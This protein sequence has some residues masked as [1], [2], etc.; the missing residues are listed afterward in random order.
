MSIR[1][2]AFSTLLCLAAL[3]S[4]DAQ[5]TRVF[6]YDLR[7][8]PLTMPAAYAI[9][10]GD[11]YEQ[12]SLAAWGA[13]GIVSDGEVAGLLYVQPFVDSTTVGSP[14]RLTSPDARPSGFV[15]VVAVRDRFV[16]IWTDVRDP[17]RP[18]VYGRTV[19]A[20]GSSLGAERPLTDRIPTG[21]IERYGD[22]ANGRVVR[23]RADSGATQAHLFV[24]FDAAGDPVGAPRLVTAV[25][26]RQLHGDITPWRTIIAFTDGDALS[27]DEERSRLDDGEIPSG[28]FHG[29]Y[30]LHG[31]GSI[32]VIEG[33]ALRTYASATETVAEESIVL[34]GFDSVAGGVAALERE[35]GGWAVTFARLVDR[36]LERSSS[37]LPFVLTL[38]RHRYDAAGMLLA[39]DTLD[40][41]LIWEGHQS[42]KI[43]DDYRL[44]SA[45]IDRGCANGSL[46]V[47]D[48]ARKEWHVTFGYSDTPYRTICREVATVAVDGACRI[49]PRANRCLAPPLLRL[50]VERTRSDSV[51]AVVV[52]DGSFERSLEIDNGIDSGFDT[53][54]LSHRRREPALGVAGDTIL[55][56]FT[57]DDVPALSHATYTGDFSPALTHRFDATGMMPH[58]GYQEIFG[59]LVDSSGA[60]RTYRG[61]G[62]AAA[63]SWP[64]VVVDN[65]RQH[66]NYLNSAHMS[67]VTVDVDKQF[68]AFPTPSGWRMIA[69]DSL[70]PV[71]WCASCQGWD[72][73]PVPRIARDPNTGLLMLQI[74]PLREGYPEERFVQRATAFIDRYGDVVSIIAEQA[75][76]GSWSEV[77]PADDRG[78]LG[79][80]SDSLHHVSSASTRLVT[81]LS[82]R[83]SNAVAHRLLGDRFLRVA[84]V[85]SNAVALDLFD[86]EGVWMASDTLVGIDTATMIVHEHPSDTT[87]TL[88]WSD[89]LGI[90]AARYSARLAP[91]VR[92][93]LLVAGSTIA[94]LAVASVGD[95]LRFVWE[96]LRYGY[97]DLYTTTIGSLPSAMSQPADTSGIPDQPNDSSGMIS[98]PLLTDRGEIVALTVVPNPARNTITVSLRLQ[99][100]WPVTITIV[101]ET[102]RSVLLRDGEPGVAGENRFALDIGELMPGAYTVVLKAGRG[103][104]EG[105]F[106]IAR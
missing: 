19:H 70:R 84:P 2:A 87:L 85:G 73:G 67:R 28:R 17:G 90:H 106:V 10:G 12:R 74:A 39:S 53:V 54:L 68:H 79:I 97:P 88:L 103:Q 18:M 56:T 55:L 20:D 65:W 57:E 5:G 40:R 63:G 26:E 101:D 30:F 80:R 16:V 9:E 34:H 23:W 29:A 78:Y 92:D 102:G 8:V 69:N 7:H 50:R 35:G 72:T 64:G 43:S 31:D 46:L 81:T 96:D 61:F 4:A 13:Y 98:I 22:P 77:I 47:Y 11:A 60:Y 15:D 21:S 91:G 45:T 36:D 37:T 3:A 49:D 95:S 59:D 82:P 62:R 1:S 42:A 89:S 51:S 32:S 24:T 14:I 104:G 86:L 71:A 27:I 38:L 99:E 66:D 41:T 58:P 105:R 83:R 48:I 94:D 25:M 100:P 93:T 52:S 44:A 76:G 6:P 33:D 75:R